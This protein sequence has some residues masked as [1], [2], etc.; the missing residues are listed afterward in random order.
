MSAQP[1][2]SLEDEKLTSLLKNLGLSETGE[3][4]R[5]GIRLSKQQF[6]ALENECKLMAKRDAYRQILHQQPE[7]MLLS[8]GIYGKLAALLVI[9]LLDSKE[10]TSAKQSASETHA[11]ENSV[12]LKLLPLLATIDR[13]IHATVVF[14]LI[15]MSRKNPAESANLVVKYLKSITNSD[16]ENISTESYL[17]MLSTLETFFPVF[18][19]QMKSVYTGQNCKRAM[20]AKVAQLKMDED[21]DVQMAKRILAAVSLSCIDE[22]AR[23]FNLN[24]YLDLFIAGTEALNR[25]IVSMSLLCVIKLWNFSAV[26]EKLPILTIV[27]KLQTTFRACESDD[28]CI[29]YLLEALS[30]LSLSKNVKKSLREDEELIEK[31]LVVLETAKDSSVVYGTLV[32]FQNL[33]EIKAKGQDATMNYLKSVSLP[34]KNEIDDD[35]V[36]AKLFNESLVLNLKLVESLK[37]L[38]LKE[39]IAI[40]CVQ[41]VYNLTHGKKAIVKEIVTQGGYNIILKYL[42]GHSV[43]REGTQKTQAESASEAV[44]SIRLKGL[45]ALAV[46][47]RSVKPSLLESEFDTRLCVPFLVELMGADINVKALPMESDPLLTMED[48]LTSFDIFSALLG[49][50]NLA[51]SEDKDLNQAIVRRAFEQHLKNLMIDSTIPEIQCA[52]WEL[53]NN[54]AMTPLLLSK[55]F[56]PEDPESMKHLDVL[57]K[58][59]NSKDEKL[60]GVLF[61]FLA[62]SALLDIVS[63]TL[64]SEEVG[65][66]A[67][68]LSIT[69]SVLKNQAHNN[70]FIVRLCALVG[71]LVDTAKKENPKALKSI[72]NLRVLKEAIRAAMRANRDPELQLSIDALV[73]FA[74]I[75]L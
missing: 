64:L 69:A 50:T 22:E 16:P 15:L 44:L 71:N 46:M 20:L 35:I 49:L 4:L 53:I 36:S 73:D 70:D 68:L 19:A 24:N 63:I 13:N 75:K 66:F 40:Q 30:Y 2:K 67:K 33:S 51:S 37:P 65:V 54:L 25:V 7:N 60:Q 12:F 52:T 21:L 3:L 6:L 26:E 47:C 62:T 34:T 5:N 56:N 72:Q 8:I 61:G 10:N 74:D 43:I 39:S 28:E 31:L 48:S 9:S 59:L 17:G 57:I 45:R 27:Q 38:D 11:A 55:F 1:K 58:L 18:P 32:I 14:T 41:I 23:N 42:T 29:E